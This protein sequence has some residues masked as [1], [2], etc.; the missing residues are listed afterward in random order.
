MNYLAYLLLIGS[1]KAIETAESPINF[2]YMKKDLAASDNYSILSSI[3]NWF[4][5]DA[6][7]ESLDHKYQMRQLAQW[8]DATGT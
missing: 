4:G 1:S 3:S 6:E 8:Y 5:G 7:D 2:S